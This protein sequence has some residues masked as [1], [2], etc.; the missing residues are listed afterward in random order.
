MP[1]QNYTDITVVLDRSGSMACIREAT[2]EGLNGFI[3]SQRAVPGDGCWS[4]VQF[5]DQYEVVYSRRSQVDVPRLTMETFVPRGS[6]AL[7][8]AVCRTID[9]TGKRLE[10]TTEGD[11]P[12]KV[13]IVVMTDGHE[14]SSKVFGRHQLNERISHQRDKYGWQFVFLGANQDSVVEATKYGIAAGNAMTYQ[15]NAAGVIKTFGAVN[16]GTRNWKLDGNDSASGFLV[17]PAPDARV[18]VSVVS[19]N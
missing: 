12:F 14:N 5:D 17:E 13:L 15:A 10:A 8:D 9:E 19:K 3:D 11:R 1:R 4:L 16:I 2:I 7:V 18:N 6:T